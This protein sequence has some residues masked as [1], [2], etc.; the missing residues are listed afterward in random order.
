MATTSSNLVAGKALAG[1]G[2]DGSHRR[3]GLKAKLAAGVAV[4][5]CAAALAFGGLKTADSATARAQPAAA[6]AN[7]A[8]AQTLAGNGYLAFSLGES[9][10][11]VAPGSGAP[12]VARTRTLAG[13]GYLEYQPGEEPSSGGG[14][15]LAPSF[16]PQP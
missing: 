13:V 7:L 10:A 4:L 9:S 12:N 11:V 1:Q 2:G 8:L 3:F 5:G 14:S 6:P 16:G 15:E